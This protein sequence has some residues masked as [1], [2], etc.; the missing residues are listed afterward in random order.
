MVSNR[1]MLDKIRARDIMKM[2]IYVYDLRAL[3]IEHDEFIETDSIGMDN[4]FARILIQEMNKVNQLKRY[5]DSHI[6][7]D[8]PKGKIDLLKSYTSGSIAFGKMH[9]DIDILTRDNDYL[10]LLKKAIDTLISRGNLKRV[11]KAPLIDKRE[12][13]DRVANIHENLMFTS[14]YCKEILESVSD[15]LKDLVSIC[16]IILDCTNNLENDFKSNK[17]TVDNESNILWS[18]YEKFLYKVITTK[19]DKN[20]F[21]VYFKKTFKNGKVNMTPDMLICHKSRGLIDS[22]LILDAKYYIQ[23]TQNSNSNSTG[24]E[25]CKYYCSVLN[26][27]NKNEMDNINK[28]ILWQD[29]IG[30]ILLY[31]LIDLDMGLERVYEFPAVYESAIDLSESID[32]IENKLI[33]IVYKSF[34]EMEISYGS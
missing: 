2:L 33:E 1:H 21:T 31:P 32:N 16:W 22:I 11:N 9:C 25:M 34:E 28:R 5:M 19:I 8:R 30:A 24:G 18:I 12:E 26:A 10:S 17:I 20:N 14:N 15:N 7:T 3:D 29:S 6:I 23:T 27:I 4:Y 13:L